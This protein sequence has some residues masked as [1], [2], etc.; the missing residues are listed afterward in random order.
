MQKLSLL[1][2]QV[3]LL[4]RIAMEVFVCIMVLFQKTSVSF[5][6][7]LPSVSNASKETNKFHTFI[8]LYVIKRLEYLNF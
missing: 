4:L 2:L 5:I 3:M 8:H 6:L 1:I 7:I